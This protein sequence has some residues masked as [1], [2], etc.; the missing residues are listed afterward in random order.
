MGNI[1]IDQE[2]TVY[3]QGDAEVGVV[4]YIHALGE[5][6]D[7]EIYNLGTREEMKIDTNKL[8]A[9]TGYGIIEGDDII[10]STV[11]G[12]KF[13]QLL[14]DGEY[15][16][17]LNCLDKGSSWFKLVKGDNLFYYTSDTGASNLQF[18][19]ENRILYE[20]V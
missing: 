3:Y 1:V 5:V 19:V 4:I 12:N 17:I 7:L 20:G 13:V 11:K 16:N 9:L 2:Q 14:R 10:I 18:R 8:E 6:T 15:I